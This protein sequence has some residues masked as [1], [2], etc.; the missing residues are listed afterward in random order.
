MKQPNFNASI[1]AIY[2]QALLILLFK[3]GCYFIGVCVLGKAYYWF[4]NSNF[5]R[6]N[7]KVETNSSSF[8]LLLHSS[9]T[10]KLCAKQGI[11]IIF[12]FTLMELSSAL[13]YILIINPTI[14]CIISAW[15]IYAIAIATHIYLSSVS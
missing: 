9:I 6:S 12:I 11:F 13:I 5:I 3:I 4:F 1:R 14:A 15:S 2:T 8:T 7:W 10:F